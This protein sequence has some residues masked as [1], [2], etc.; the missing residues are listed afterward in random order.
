MG[1]K[2]IT[3]SGI[4]LFIRRQMQIRSSRNP[5]ETWKELKK[6]FF[7]KIY[8]FEREKERERESATEILCECEQMWRRRAREIENLKPTCR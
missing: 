1:G 4:C 6:K 8:L 7:F 5:E 2:K 3:R